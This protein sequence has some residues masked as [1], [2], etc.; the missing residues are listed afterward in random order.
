MHALMP[1]HIMPDVNAWLQILTTVKSQKYVNYLLVMEHGADPLQELRERCASTPS[2]TDWN[3]IDSL[4]FREIRETGTLTLTR[5][6]SVVDI[7]VN[8]N[9]LTLSDRG[10]LTGIN[11][12]N[13]STF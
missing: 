8:T 1:Q 10:T 12:F 9:V 2:T 6:C 5:S 3:D 13:H 4:V 7:L 11:I